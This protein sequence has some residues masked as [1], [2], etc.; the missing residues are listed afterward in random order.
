MVACGGDPIASP[1]PYHGAAVTSH[2][3]ENLAGKP[4][5]RNRVAVLGISL[6]LVVAAGLG[7]LLPA[8]AGLASAAAPYNLFHAGAGTIGLA[9]FWSGR[10]Q[11]A[12]GFNFAFGLIDL[13]Q[14]A[15]GVLDLPPARMFA[16]RPADHVIHVVLGLAL[17]AV[18][19]PLMRPAGRASQRGGR[20]LSSRA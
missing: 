10:A 12:A 13:Y 1:A 3:K 18:S 9:I 14:A 16:L 6:L 15:A 4:A 8:G 2:D 20:R 17:V 5:R 7:A 19:W 11:A